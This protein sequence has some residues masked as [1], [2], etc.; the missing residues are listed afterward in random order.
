MPPSRNRRRLA[1]AVIAAVVGVLLLSG[2]GTG[3]GQASNYSEL[4]DNFIESC[5]ATVAEAWVQE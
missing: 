4:E 2:C 5:E 3:Q 1:P